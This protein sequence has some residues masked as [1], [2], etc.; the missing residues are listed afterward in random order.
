MTISAIAVF[1]VNEAKRLNPAGY[2][3]PPP[4]FFFLVFFGKPFANMILSPASTLPLRER[5]LPIL[6]P[7]ATN[8][9]VDRACPHLS[10]LFDLWIG[11]LREARLL[12]EVLRSFLLVPKAPLL[13]P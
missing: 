4:L 5:P 2:R 12:F 13:L 11:I 8:V 9:S 6:D 10:R 7:S 3:G 1:V